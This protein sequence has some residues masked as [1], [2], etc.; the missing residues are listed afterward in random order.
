MI[1]PNCGKETTFSD[2]CLHCGEQT[3]FTRRIN[4][5]SIGNAHHIIPPLSQQPL[6]MINGVDDHTIQELCAANAHTKREINQLTQDISTAKQAHQKQL[7]GLLAVGLLAGLVIGAS[8]MYLFGIVSL[9][10]TSTG[11]ADQVTLA[12]APVVTGSTSETASPPAFVTFD[13]NPSK[14]MQPYIKGVYPPPSQLATEELPCLCNIDKWLFTGWNTSPDGNGILFRH[15]DTISEQVT[16]ST[17]LYAQWNP[18]PSVIHQR[19]ETQS[20][21]GTADVHASMQESHSENVDEMIDASQ[22]EDIANNPNPQPQ[23]HDAK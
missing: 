17:T 6:S 21:Q 22:I 15:G 7:A 4:H 13:L 8:V 5:Q 23:E 1:C 11:P 2:V 9:W 19:E 12:E 10:H 16:S 20:S 3:E 14:E 18:F